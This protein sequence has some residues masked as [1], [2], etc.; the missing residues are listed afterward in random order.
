MPVLSSSSYRSPVLFR[1]GHVGT[2]YPSL[3]RKVRDVHYDRERISTPDDDFLDLDWVRNGN[4]SCVIVSHGLEGSS[5]R[6]YVLG[7][8]KKFA[9][10]NWDAVGWNCRSCSGEINLQP[11]LY[12]H[13]ATQDIKLIVDHVVSKGYKQIALVGFSMGGSMTMKYLGENGSDVPDEVTAGVAFSTPTDLGG[14]SGEL[15]KKSNRIYMRRFLKKLAIKFE[16]KNQQY[17]GLFDLDDILETKSFFEFDS[18][19]TA[20]LYGFKDAADFYE[21]SR[22]D[23]YFDGIQVPTLLV[24]AKNDPFLSD[25]CYPYDRVRNLEYIT[26]E[27]PNRGGHVGFMQMGEFT[28]SED[29]AYEFVQ[30]VVNQD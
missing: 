10:N 8:I 20:P 1:N 2:L 26:L 28:W 18:R 23:Q 16:Q 29:R 14:S 19:Y 6:P 12:H 21:S 25:T 24:N 9:S 27:T 22:C 7:M 11:I 15:E 13:G 4:S 30:A 5:S 17:P 3:F